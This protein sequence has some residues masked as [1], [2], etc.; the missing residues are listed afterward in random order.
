MFLLPAFTN[1]WT[2]G[3]LTDR[4]NFILS[5]QLQGLVPA[6]YQ[7]PLRAASQVLVWAHDP[8]EMLSLDGEVFLH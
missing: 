4:G 7:E 1:I 6:Q 8:D 5:E 2:R 3:F